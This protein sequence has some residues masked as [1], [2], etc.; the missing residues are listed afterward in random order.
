MPTSTPKPASPNRTADLSARAACQLIERIETVPVLLKGAVDV[1]QM[2]FVAIAYVTDALWIACAVHDEAGF[3]LRAGDPL[4][5]E[6]TLC[7]EVRATRQSVIITDV[8]RDP[9]YCDHPT[10]K[11][12]A[13]RSYI[14]VPIEL[15]DGTYYGN[16][17]AL[18][19]DPV[20][21]DAAGVTATFEL[22]AKLIGYR[23]AGE[24]DRDID[25][26]AARRMLDDT[27]RLRGFDQD[28]IV[29][30]ET[31]TALAASELADERSAREEVHTGLS[32]EHDAVSERLR[33]AESQAS[34]REEF[35]AVLGH[36][37]RNPLAAITT[38]AELL[39]QRNT[40]PV[41]V[42]IVN[43]IALS[44]RRMSDII[45]N[46][47]DFTRIRMSGSLP[48]D[49]K[50]TSD[51]SMKLRQTAEEI[52]DAH[53]LRE[54]AIRVGEIP[55]VL[56]DPVR[57]QQLCSNLLANAVTH[58]DSTRQVIFDASW[59]AAGVRIMVENGGA[60][61]SPAA[62]A[63]I[64]QPFRQGAGASPREGLGLGLHICAQVAKAHGGRLEV[65]S[66]EERTR[67]IA[68]MPLRSV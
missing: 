15:P 31:A 27:R 45:A 41:Q 60:A 7:R 40:D 6:T 49:L 12:Y 65:E 36:D 19:P 38:Y 61:I 67:F 54:F 34:L 1:T 43:R 62:L 52:Q 16:L 14:S 47:M 8:T 39:R 30:L 64:F 5:V 63:S 26:A 32:D 58:G 25:K 55:R 10:P 68:T 46:V 13:F 48:V 21:I 20:R 56:A 44:A 23:I 18:D 53:P 4:D 24:I 51:L 59:S 33:V 35:I 57:L 42:G 28:R 22:L 37:L 9:R 29:S 50:P 11:R 66:N 17:C 2:R 3:G